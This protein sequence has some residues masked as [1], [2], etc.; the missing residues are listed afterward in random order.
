MPDINEL[1]QKELAALVAR[2]EAMVLIER[3]I[4]ALDNVYA[5]AEV[6]TWLIDATR[7][8]FPEPEP[9]PEALVADIQD[10]R[11]EREILNNVIADDESLQEAYRQAVQD[12]ID[13]LT[14]KQRG[15]LPLHPTGQVK[16]EFGRN[17]R[18]ALSEP[19]KIHLTAQTLPGLQERGLPIPSGNAI[20]RY[21]DAA[22]RKTLESG[23][24]VDLY[25]TVQRS[26]RTEGAGG[27]Y[28]LERLLSEQHVRQVTQSLAASTRDGF[29]RRIYEYGF[30]LSA[31]NPQGLTGKVRWVTDGNPDS[32]HADLA[33]H[34]FEGPDATVQWKSKSINGPRHDPT[35][36][37]E[38]TNCRCSLSYETNAGVWL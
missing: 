5:A 37:K 16:A 17:L 9:E 31:N 29:E 4:A 27:N 23:N 3:S 10:I 28:S 1:F 20:G 34:I 11:Q 25:D 26:I 14:P 36:T 24:V 6:R 8:L 15:R 21:A 13:S 12:T 32:R 35:N 2:D 18:N 38:W 7:I 30:Q 33:G 19:L 22:V